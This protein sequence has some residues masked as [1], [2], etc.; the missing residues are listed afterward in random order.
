MVK[1][2]VR[3]IEFEPAVLPERLIARAVIEQSSSSAAYESR[4]RD[5]CTR[6]PLQSWTLGGKRMLA[7]AGA[8]LEGRGWLTDLGVVESATMAALRTHG[9]NRQ[10]GH[11]TLNIQT[12]WFLHPRRCENEIW[13]CPR[14]DIRREGLAW[15]FAQPATELKV[16]GIGLEQV[17]EAGR[18]IVRA[19]AGQQWSMRLSAGGQP[20][21]GVEVEILPPENERGFVDGRS[22]LAVRARVTNR[23]GEPLSGGKAVLLGLDEETSVALDLEPGQSREIEIAAHLKERRGIIP[24]AIR[25]SHSRCAGLGFRSIWVPPV[26]LESDQPWL[27][28][29]Y[30]ENLRS[31]MHRFTFNTWRE[32]EPR[33]PC[34][35]GGVFARNL[36]SGLAGLGFGRT[37][38]G[39][40]RLWLMAMRSCGY[41]PESFDLLIPPLGTAAWLDA[42]Y[43]I[44]NDGMGFVMIQ[45]G[46][47]FLRADQS[48]REEMLE[49]DL[50][51]LERA[52]ATLR[53]F[54]HWD[55]R[56]EDHS[57]PVEGI[58]TDKMLTGSPFAQSL[59]LAGTLLVRR[60]LDEALPRET[61][62]TP[63]RMPQRISALRDRFDQLSQRLR[64]GLDKACEEGYFSD[65]TSDQDQLHPHTYTNLTAGMVLSDPDLGE[66]RFTRWDVLRK[67]VE[68]NGA[69]HAP[70][71]PHRV[72]TC[73]Y[74]PPHP[75]L[76]HNAYSQIAM[77]VN[78]LALDREE[79]AGKYLSDLLAGAHGDFRK[80]MLSDPGYTVLDW[81]DLREHEFSRY[82][83]PEG[84]VIGHDEVKINPGNGVNCS[85]FLYMIDRMM[86]ITPRGDRI[87][88]RPELAGQQ[89]W[90]VH[91]YRTPLGPVSYRL[92]RGEAGTDDEVTGE[93]SSPVKVVASLSASLGDGLRAIARVDGKT[94]PCEVAAEAEGHRIILHVPAGEHRFVVAVE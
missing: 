68:F 73:P 48:L 16:E 51:D 69:Y 57:E 44:G 92:N 67:T 54:L 81:T 59:C 4:W 90:T 66:D 40:T 21:V 43:N 34:Y 60:A 23:S 45:W 77:I 79:M 86:G 27:D 52:A 24:L 32:D 88:I 74:W 49:A 36:H 9:E 75:G 42:D 87:E 91:E 61:A 10:R 17:R 47:L 58:R 53:R 63:V 71:R 30:A 5:E 25:Y 72:L 11:K 39:W 76:S 19:A 80:H 29:M 3:R 8:M 89:T 37:L 85:Y 33:Y 1:Q 13:I 65:V 6:F 28:G 62:K 46:K 22:P 55:G 64:K 31:M 83:V 78:C 50:P 38:W 84:A 12:T 14:Y 20:P 15:E 41:M 26:V 56:I 82:I 70:G 18:L 2:P 94:V 93:I 35:V 7:G